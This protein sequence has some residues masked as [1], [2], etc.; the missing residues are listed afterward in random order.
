MKIIENKDAE[1]IIISHYDNAKRI[2]DSI[3][4]TKHDV[5]NSNR[6]DRINV[7][8]NDMETHIDIAKYMVDKYINDECPSDVM[9]VF[10]TNLIIGYHFNNLKK[11][12]QNSESLSSEL[13]K[14]IEKLRS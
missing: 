7:W 10:R 8:L 12:H 4:D 3:L 5:K 13:G 11:T 2:S 9:D 6:T 14:Q 1:K